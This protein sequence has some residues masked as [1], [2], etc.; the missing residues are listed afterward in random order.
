MREEARGG[1]PPLD[2][3]VPFVE[4]RVRAI[5]SIGQWE[6]FSSLDGGGV[7]SSFAEIEHYVG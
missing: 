4:E 3:I 1:K 6:H 7:P 2:S 5:V